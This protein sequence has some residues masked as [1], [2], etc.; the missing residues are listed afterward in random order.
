MSTSKTRSNDQ[1]HL[2]LVKR[3]RKLTLSLSS[4]S[5]E[6]NKSKTLLPSPPPSLHPPQQRTS[7]NHVAVSSLPPY[8]AHLAG[9]TSLS[10]S[11]STPSFPR[12]SVTNIQPPD[13]P[14]HGRE[15]DYHHHAEPSRLPPRPPSMP[16]IQTMSYPN[17][18]PSLVRVA[19]EHPAS[20]KPASIQLGPTSKPSYRWELVPR[21]KLQ[22]DSN[23]VAHHSSPRRGDDKEN[24]D[25][26]HTRAVASSSRV[27]LSSSV[28]VV[29][30]PRK[31]ATR[32]PGTVVTSCATTFTPAGSRANADCPPVKGQCWGIKKDGSRCSRKVRPLF[33][34]RQSASN[35][36][37]RTN[38]GTSAPARLIKG[39]TSSEP[40][41]MSDSE[42][43]KSPKRTDNFADDIDETYCY[44]HVAEVNKTP[45]FYHTHFD[46]STFIQ[47]SDWFGTTSLTDHTQALLRKHMSKPL[48]HIDRSELGYL[49]MYE[50]RD[51]STLTHICLKVGR[52]TNVFRRLGEWRYQCQSKDPLLR[53]FHPCL[54]GQGLI[55]G[56]HA[57]S[58]A[59][60][61]LSHRWEHLVHTELAGIGQRVSRSCTDCGVRHREIFMIPKRLDKGLDE[62]S[63]QQGNYEGFQLAEKV[64]LKWMRFVRSLH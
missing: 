21:E 33:D 60:V 55:S 44:Q 52:T 10:S 50:L 15:D 35:E 16:S 53:S 2:G 17:A 6:D 20:L 34:A 30:P 14:L 38:R 19:N 26:Y 41:V 27:D 64:V 62:T 7:H 45:G 48:S 22:A 25:E 57:P 1:H 46:Q 23:F 39:T 56:M 59:G 4:P 36:A 31:Q 37:K 13:F 49:Y 5:L 24:R 51:H 47:F 63:T 28:G 9:T 40:L 18:F 8:L 58:V 54:D 11:R 29:T 42:D 3:L 32:L 43:E 12:P 61:R